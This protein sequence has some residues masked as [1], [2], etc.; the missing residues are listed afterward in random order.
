MFSQ[1]LRAQKKPRKKRSGLLPAIFRSLLSLLLHAVLHPPHTSPAFS[2]AP[3]PCPLCWS[4]QESS[5]F[6]TLSFELSSDFKTGRTRAVRTAYLL[7]LLGC[8]VIQDNKI[9]IRHIK[10]WQ[11]IHSC[12]C[13]VNILI[14][15]I[16]C[17][18]CVFRSSSVNAHKKR[19]SSDADTDERFVKRAL[20][21]LKY[22]QRSCPNAGRSWAIHPK[23]LQSDLSH[24]SISSEDLIHLFW[25]NI[26]GEIPDVKY[27]AY[28]PHASIA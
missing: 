15:H 8:V 7:W 24:G 2:S 17:P 27:S 23:Y 28:T 20:I 6:Q 16:C 25:A 11:S 5:K 26:E 9:S 3:L 12:L 19:Q 14:H 1:L 21:M 13:I 4:A 18:P 22:Q 10:A